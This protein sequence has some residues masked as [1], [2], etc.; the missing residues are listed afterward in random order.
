MFES[1]FGQ[2]SEAIRA[3]IVFF[4]VLALIGG[5]VWLVRRFGAN[6]LGG[7]AARGRQPRLAV[8]DSA[9]VDNRRRLLLIRRDN[10]EHLLM[11]GGPTDVVVEQSIVRAQTQAR[12]APQG[13][14]TG[15]TE[16]L[17]RPIPLDDSVSW[18]LQPQAEP[19]PLRPQV[20]PTQLRPPR[21]AA[22]DESASWQAATQ[23]EPLPRVVRPLHS[24]APEDAGRWQ[25]V[26]Q[27]APTP[28]ADPVV[29]MPRIAAAGAIEPI[30]RAQAT[31]PEPGARTEPVVQMPRPI[32]PVEA[33]AATARPPQQQ[34][35]SQPPL[36][37]EPAFVQP[38]LPTPAPAREEPT[39]D[40]HA[41]EPVL[42]VLAGK[43]TA[44]LAAPRAPEPPVDAAPDVPPPAAPIF[45]ATTEPTADVVAAEHPP[46]PPVPHRK[47]AVALS[48]EADE[49]LAEMALR[50]EAALRG[51]VGSAG[52][53]GNP[54]PLFRAP[55]GK[56][57]DR[58]PAPNAPPE[59]V[60]ITPSEPA[61][62]AKPK[63]GGRTLY[64]N[65]EEEMA[66][67]LGRPAAGNKG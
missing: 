2:P 42:P 20:E 59:H 27:P 67:L 62:P 44:D 37:R 46:T 24:P 3:I 18:P 12:E 60:E 35:A 29:R 45:P 63:P 50:L 57:A 6:R 48:A 47:Q 64:A 41:G 23:P 8:I 49:N 39:A 52:H 1:L 61:A 31:R 22:I 19:T 38:P 34:P 43:L 30:L 40:D 21:P 9:P 58:V 7:G 32:P 11:I 55:E 28:Q 33:P 54:T 15:P 16:A 14:G 5:T 65:L 66:S 4:V 13:R 53:T 26:P 10:V 51:P 25:Q 56:V 36:A 17:P